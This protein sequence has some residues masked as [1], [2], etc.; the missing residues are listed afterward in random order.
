MLPKYDIDM[1]VLVSIMHMFHTQ[2]H[3]QAHT[4]TH[5][6]THSCSTFKN[7]SN[8]VEVVLKNDRAGIVYDESRTS[9]DKRLYHFESGKYMYIV[10][11]VYNIYIYIYIYIC[12]YKANVTLCFL[13][14]STAQTHIHVRAYVCVCVMHICCMYVFM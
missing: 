3:K 2:P 1:R 9:R 8:A 10:I 12:I 6:C 13:Q 14:I 11:C 4:Y 5:S 7:T